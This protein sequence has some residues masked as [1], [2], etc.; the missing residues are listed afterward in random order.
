MSR[1]QQGGSASLSA[2]GFA[3][4]QLKRLRRATPELRT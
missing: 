3:P 1:E 4:L 2:E